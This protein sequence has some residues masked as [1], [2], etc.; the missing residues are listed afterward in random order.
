MASRDPVAR[1]AYQNERN[2]R[3]AAGER[4]VHAESRHEEE[5]LQLL[6]ILGV[7]ELREGWAWVDPQ[8]LVQVVG[9]VLEAKAFVLATGSERLRLSERLRSNKPGSPRKKLA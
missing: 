1:R 2:K 3:R 8:R 7:L 6:R 9:N 5:A 4:L